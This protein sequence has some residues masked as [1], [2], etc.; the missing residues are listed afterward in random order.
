MPDF[1]ELF[2]L[3]FEDNKTP[4][5]LKSLFQCISK[6]AKNN[7]ARLSN[8]NHLSKESL[9]NKYSEIPHKCDDPFRVGEE[10]VNDFF[11]DLPNWRSPR[12]NLNIGSPVNIVAS[13]VYSLSLDTNILA[14]NKGLAGQ[15]L[16]AEEIVTNILGNLIDQK[17][18]RGLFTYG[19]SGTNLYGIKLGIHKAIPESNKT[20]IT[21][22]IKILIAEDSHYAQVYSADWLGVGT[23]NVIKISAKENR[24]S[25]LKNAEEL[26]RTYLD[27]N[28]KIGAILLNGGTS[29][30]HTIDEI[31]KFVQLR[32]KLV[33]EYNLKYSPHIHVDAVIG[34]MWLFFK[35]YDFRE[36]PLNIKEGILK[37]IEH[38]YNRISEL[39]YADSWGVD[40]HKGVGG[41]PV[42]SSAFIFNN[43]EDMEFF[44]KEGNPAQGLFGL[45][46]ITERFNAKS[47]VNYTLEN[48]RSA[49]PFLSALASIHTMGMNGFRT[50][51]AKLVE[52]VYYIHK[53]VKDKE[54]IEVK[55]PY[56]CGFVVMIRL[57]PP[58]LANNEV[59]T[60]E[61]DDK[62]IVRRINEYNREFYNW[63]KRTRMS[64]NISPEYSYSNYSYKFPCGEG[65]H[66]L[67][68]YPVSP[69]VN[70]LHTEELINTIV[71]QKKAF[72]KM[73]K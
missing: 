38:Q 4:S 37:T 12:L 53:L 45:H 66:T 2:P 51:L 13:A 56:R 15:A 30:R 57:Y 65:M 29:Y 19:G 43:A 22:K 35:G 62:Q 3:N 27:K 18:T 17:N 25:S 68:I 1:K 52:N 48:S 72:D 28:I 55:D 64:K 39:K 34:W 7:P 10:I 60:L 63:D 9:I 59:K 73:R 20:G 46:Q 26:L 50:Y 58:E 47:A 36:N 69:H 42:D 31:K 11:V 71:S 33:K 23:D 14:V 41:C 70:P 61:P 44:S 8:S 67:K 5:Y 40:F 32:D 54:D 49:G 24:T 6:K 16:I 21:E